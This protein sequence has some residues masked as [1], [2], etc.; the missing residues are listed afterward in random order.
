MSPSKIFSLHGKGLKLHTEA[1]IDP[2]LNGLDPT[3]IEEIHLGGNTIGVKASQ[4]LAAFLEKATN[5]KVIC[6]FY[7]TAMTR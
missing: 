4:A 3:K 6:L 7:G 1:D 5:L 2:W